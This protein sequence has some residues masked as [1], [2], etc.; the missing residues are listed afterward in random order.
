MNPQ[1]TINLLA[2]K[3]GKSL[4]EK[5]SVISVL[6]NKI[7]PR[8]ACE[9]IT[10]ELFR[11]IH[12]LVGSSGTFG[13]DD[14]YQ[15]AIALEEHLRKSMNDRYIEQAALDRIWSYFIALRNAVSVINEELRTN[16]RPIKSPLI[17]CS[18]ELHIPPANILI[19]S[20]DEFFSL[21]LK[22][23]LIE[24]EHNAVTVKDLEQVSAELANKEY[25][26]IF[27][28]VILEH[29]TG[30]DIARHIRSTYNERYIPIIFITSL[31][32]D[33]D[34]V[35][36]MLSGGDIVFTKPVN[37]DIV[38]A[39]LFSFHRMLVQLAQTRKELTSQTGS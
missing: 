5:I 6:I 14:L 10:T 18:Q 8:T 13:Y 25:D 35:N 24:D 7:Q 21:G 11:Q 12:N 29:C 30:M 3:F 22:A 17:Y 38:R 4:S 1:E 39:Q 32:H 16:D 19:V 26:Y 28:E 9:E 34:F 37:I 27:S 23:T 31:K 33:S 15:K 20:D 36:C 2:I